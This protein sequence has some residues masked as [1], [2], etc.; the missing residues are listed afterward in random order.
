M[1]E[2]V[3]RAAVA[4]DAYRRQPDSAD[5]EA[6]RAYWRDVTLGEEQADRLG[7]SAEQATAVAHAASGSLMLDGEGTAR[8]VTGAGAGRR[9]AAG[10]IAALC[11]AGFLSESAPDGTGR[12]RIEPTADGRRALMVWQR[13][14]PAPVVKDKR[15]ER[16]AL[17]PLHQGEE[18]RRRAAAAARRMQEWQRE[19][20]AK[21]A[22][23][24]ARIA[25]RRREDELNEQWR[26]ANGIRNPWAKRP[27]GWTAEAQA[28]AD[29]AAAEEAAEDAAREAAHVCEVREPEPATVPA[30]PS[31]AP[32][33][34][35]ALFRHRVTVVGSQSRD[36]CTQPACRS[37]R[38]HPSPYPPCGTARLTVRTRPAPP[39][40]RAPGGR[41]WRQAGLRRRRSGE[42]PAPRLPRPS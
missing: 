21:W 7:W 6:V 28:E 42:R 18:A 22:E 12:R 27:A 40:R 4:A 35:A 31:A 38:P 3:D 11:A 23:A 32:A 29:R 14:S 30:E 39:G 17:A 20:E 5:P 26:Q 15:T 37:R 16:E 9:V 33:D 1:S 34:V 2:T 24:E 36:R 10:R 8:H 41:T 13:W 25:V 19:T